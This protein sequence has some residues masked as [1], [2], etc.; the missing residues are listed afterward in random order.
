MEIKKAFIK[1]EN[2]IDYGVDERKKENEEIK[3][4]LKNNPSSNKENKLRSIIIKHRK[5]F[6]LKKFIEFLY[7]LTLM[8]E[9][10]REKIRE[11]K[12]K[13]SIFYNE[14]ILKKNLKKKPFP[15]DKNPLTFKKFKNKKYSRT[16]SNKRDNIYKSA[17]KCQKIIEKSNRDESENW[18][19]EIQ[20][21]KNKLKGIS[22]QN[23][24][25]EK[26]FIFFI[27]IKRRV[28]NII[29]LFKVF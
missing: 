11:N 18:R 29:I 1:N 14:E 15:L 19:I 16:F 24:D 13:H 23:S 2:Y 25:N 3:E 21:I 8:R 10:I 22:N 20:R 9:K 17:I 6:K 7:N 28:K 4:I 27:K 12:I 5:Y 26:L